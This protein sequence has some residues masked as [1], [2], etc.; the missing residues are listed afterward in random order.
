MVTAAIIIAS[1]ALIVATVA[2]I[3]AA[4]KQEIIKET[5]VEVVKE[6]GTTKNPFTYDE[7]G[8]V[9]RLNGSLKV[10]GSISCINKDD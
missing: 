9:Y 10:D 8:K 6:S 5:T 7:K 4:K 2:I 1:I 3:M